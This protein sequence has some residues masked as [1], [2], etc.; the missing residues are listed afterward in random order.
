MNILSNP[1][2][3]ESVR[4][5]DQEIQLVQDLIDESI[6]NYGQRIVYFPGQMI[7]VDSVL[8]EPTSMSFTEYHELPAITPDVEQF[9]N[10]QILISKFGASFGDTTDFYLSKTHFNLLGS[11][12]QPEAGDV[13]YHPQ[14][15][16]I[17]KIKNVPFRFNYHGLGHE[18]TWKCEVDI[19][20]T[21]LDEF[22]TGNN[23]LD[24]ILGFVNQE[25]LGYSGG[26]NQT[27]KDAVSENKLTNNGQPLD[28]IMVKPARDPFN[29]FN[30]G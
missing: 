8:S 11:K 17:F 20:S 23:E 26:N 22:A 27:I 29:L 10:S 5:T 21:D 4:A 16:M 2:L 19:Y 9:Q 12:P 30:K 6:V 14:S 13:I 1:Y 24:D 7:D 15:R 3:T 18:F 25:A 28:K